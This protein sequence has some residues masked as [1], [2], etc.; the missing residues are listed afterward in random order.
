MPRFPKPFFKKSHQSWYVQIDGRQ[1]RLGPDRDAAHRRY[2]ELM[3]AGPKVEPPPSRT[4]SPRLVDIFDHFLA[5]CRDQRAPDTY[6]WYRWRLQMFTDEI[7]SGLTVATLKPFHLDDWL[8]KHPAWASG[9]KNGMCRAVQRALRW[10]ERRGRIERSPIAH[11]EKPRL[12]RR[13]IVVTPAQFEEM[14]EC[15]PQQEFRDLIVAT[16]ETAARPQESLVVEARHVD[17]ENNRWVFPP[18]E[19]KVDRWPRVVYLSPVAIEITRRLMLLHPSGP[20]FRNSNGDPWTTFSVNCAFIRLQTT[21]GMKRLKEKGLMPPALPRLRGSA[22]RDEDCRA[23][24]D[25]QV[26]RTAE[27]HRGAGQEARSEAVPLP[28]ASLL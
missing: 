27:G 13:T 28:S 8:G 15:V 14:L 18:E 21:I 11:Y 9:T 26:H 12:G 2:H 10:A 23:A 1:V 25:R 4:S 20:L 24:Q 19:S 17:L 22:R 6:E 3:A 5:F 7:A 16:W